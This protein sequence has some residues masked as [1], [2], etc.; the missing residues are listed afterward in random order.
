MRLSGKTAADRKSIE[1]EGVAQESADRKATYGIKA[2]RL[3]EGVLRFTMT[4]SGPDG[5]PADTLEE[6]YTKKK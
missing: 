5:K 4:H 2:E 3:P 1:F 6:T